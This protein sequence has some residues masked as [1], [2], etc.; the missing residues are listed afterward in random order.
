MRE[1]MNDQH[2]PNKAIPGAL[3]REVARSAMEAIQKENKAH[4]VI[5]DGN[6]VGN[7]PVPELR[8]LHIGQSCR[9]YFPHAISHY[10]APWANKDPENLP[11]PVYPG[12][13]GNQVFD[14]AALEQYYK[15]WI[16]LKNE[17][18]GVHC[19]ECGCWNKT[20]HHVFL[21][22]FD[23]VLDILA[24]HKIGF[25]LWE[26]VGDFGILNSGR[27]DVDYEDWY[28]YK[29]DKKLLELLKKH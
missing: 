20:P 12:K 25:A 23:D 7:D 16:A 27:A 17:G 22:W 21:S 18:V 15:P 11:Q 8:D 24:S 3:Y 28:G 14:R 29:L 2:S 19:G 6:N 9:G 4:L 5:A 1:D 13:T 10:K 26:F